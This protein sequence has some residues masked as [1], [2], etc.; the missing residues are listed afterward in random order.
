M[1][2]PE[3]TEPTSEQAAEGERELSAVALTAALGLTQPLLGTKLPA[4]NL[5]Q[6][7]LH[8]AFLADSEFRRQAAAAIL[9]HGLFQVPSEHLI[10]RWVRTHAPLDQIREV[11]KLATDVI[12]SNEDAIKWLSEPNPATDDR[13]PLDLLGDQEGY[14][15]VKNLLMRIEYG[16]LA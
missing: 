6:E 2:M 15:R 1:Y 13:A 14:E 16:V 7:G 8:R 11:E 4:E 5:L 10:E 12:G 3:Q 9:E